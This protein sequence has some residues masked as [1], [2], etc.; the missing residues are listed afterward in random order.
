[1]K[2][3]FS[4]HPR[5]PA[6]SLEQQRRC[7][8]PFQSQN[9]KGSND[10]MRQ[11]VCR[12]CGKTLLKIWPRQVSA[13]L[14]QCTISTCVDV[15]CEGPTGQPPQGPPPMRTAEAATQTRPEEVLEEKLRHQRVVKRWT[16]LVAMIADRE[17]GP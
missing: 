1:M 3:S 17:H 13:D 12:P 8:H 4:L 6:M 10:D 7:L 9:M 15:L 16:R 14:L 5:P 11:V 2:L